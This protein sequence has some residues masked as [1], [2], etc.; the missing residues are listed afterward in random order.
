[1]L[2]EAMVSISKYHQASPGPYLD[3]Q[4]IVKHWIS[5]S[6]DQLRITIKKLSKISRSLP[7]SQYILISSESSQIPLQK[8]EKKIFFVAFWS[9]PPM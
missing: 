6:K 2:P 3:R 9:C 5:C 7:L 1:M 4:T 8:T